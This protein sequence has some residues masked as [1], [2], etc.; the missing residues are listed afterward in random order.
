MQLANQSAV[1]LDLD[2]QALDAA[3]TQRNFAPNMQ[4]II[5]RRSTNS[6][7]A[8]RVLGEPLRL[9]YGESPTERLDVF[10]TK[11][12]GAPV[13]IHIHGGAWRVGSA[14][15]TAFMAELFVNAGAHLVLPDFASVTDVDGDLFVLANQA[16]RAVAWVY[17]NAASFGGDPSRIYV[18]GH[19]SGGH[20]AG[21]IA[22]TD[23]ASEFGLPA[24]IVK[25]GLCSSGMFDL[26]PVR[27]SIRSEYLSFT[28]EMENALSPIR[29]L[30]K[31]SA[32]LLVSYGSYESPE[33]I[34]QAKGFASAVE[35]A[36]KPVELIVGEGYNHFE[37]IETLANPHGIL[38]RAV[39]GQMRLGK[40]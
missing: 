6:D 3:Y 36:G 25:G 24:D 11:D 30:D 35:A 22:T 34:R 7:N 28:D 19:S 40:E 21:V 16:R 1:W 29:H 37:V 18:S 39:L 9:A 2:Q 8:R 23:W 12:T 20:L 15:G 4:Q 14:R 17:E 27:L 32:P 5:A 26:K 38:G 10:R 31:L 33:F 13:H